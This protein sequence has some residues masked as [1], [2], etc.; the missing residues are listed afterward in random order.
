MK[1]PNPLNLVKF[2]SDLAG[3]LLLGIE[4]ANQAISGN[5]DFFGTA[6][7]NCLLSTAGDQRLATLEFTETKR[8]LAGGNTKRSGSLACGGDPAF[9]VVRHIRAEYF[10]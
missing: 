1:S 4:G 9:H 6:G 3:T 2:E 10:I 5:L 8:W 7:R